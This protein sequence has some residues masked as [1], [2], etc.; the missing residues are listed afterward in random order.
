MV[1]KDTLQKQHTVILEKI[2][3]AEGAFKATGRLGG[4]LI[5]ILIVMAGY[6]FNKLESQGQEIASIKQA[7]AIIK[8]EFK[9]KV[10]VDNEWKRSVDERLERV[11]YKE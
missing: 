9:S 10:V 4:V 7:V 11:L 5:A 6:A 8:V 1:N 2:A 3:T